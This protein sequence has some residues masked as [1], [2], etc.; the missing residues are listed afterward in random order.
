[1]AE[2][3]ALVIA[4]VAVIGS[5]LL[6]V[7]WRSQRTGLRELIAMAGHARLVATHAWNAAYSAHAR[8]AAMD[9]RVRRLERTAHDH[10]GYGVER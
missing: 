7:A 3:I 10:D 1:M 2:L 4:P 5:V 9:E 6:A 8:L